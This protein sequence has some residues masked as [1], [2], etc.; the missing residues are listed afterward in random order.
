MFLIYEMWALPTVV[1]YFV[2][3]TF[4]I[5]D[6]TTV[7]NTCIRGSQTV[8]RGPRVIHGPQVVRGPQVVHDPQMVH[9]P[10]VVH[11]LQVVHGPQV[12]RGM[13]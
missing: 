2:P 9:D 5:N 3:V 8:V 4:L 13:V 12:V 11:D 7:Q 1:L 6:I 10:Q